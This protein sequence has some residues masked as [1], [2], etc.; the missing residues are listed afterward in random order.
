MGG[1]GQNL[2]NKFKGHENGDTFEISP[3]LLLQYCNKKPD[4]VLAKLVKPDWGVATEVIIPPFLVPDR[5]VAIFVDDF[6]PRRSS[7]DP[8]T[9]A[10]RVR[11]GCVDPISSQYLEYLGFDPTLKSLCNGFQGHQGEGAKTFEIHPDVLLRFC[12]KFPHSKL[13]KEVL[14]PYGELMKDIVPYRCRVDETIWLKTIVP[15]FPVPDRLVEAFTKK[16]GD[17][18]NNQLKIALARESVLAPDYLKHFGFDPHLKITIRYDNPG[19]GQSDRRTVEILPTETV[20]KLILRVASVFEG[21]RLGKMLRGMT[22]DD[23]DSAKLSR[24]NVS[25]WGGPMKSKVQETWPIHELCEDARSD[26]FPG[27]QYMFNGGDTGAAYLGFSFGLT[28]FQ[29]DFWSVP[30]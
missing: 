30:Q 8:F 23:Y 5:V 2:C 22:D 20:R 12:E 24:G 17:R 3:T 21:A 13:A 28:D 9:D 15:P 19:S 11:L 10:T 27:N 25:L 29:K 18:M 16:F 7:D 26:E 6:A 1:T 4:S 14:R